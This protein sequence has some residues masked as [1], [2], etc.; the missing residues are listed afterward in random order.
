M[1]EMTGESLWQITTFR[2]LPVVLARILEG[3]LPNKNCWNSFSKLY[4]SIR[5]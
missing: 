4:S 5:E 2:V 1:S 3:Q